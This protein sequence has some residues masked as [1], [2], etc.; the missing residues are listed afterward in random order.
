METERQQINIKE[1]EPQEEMCFVGKV[2]L[3]ALLTSRWQQTRAS[4]REER[5]EA[6]HCF[7]E[8]KYFTVGDVR[9]SKITSRET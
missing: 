7:L 4:K 8:A 9:K 1:R 2:A 6:G 5:R 3:P